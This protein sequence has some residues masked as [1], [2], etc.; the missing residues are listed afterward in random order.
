MSRITIFVEFVL[1]VPD[2]PDYWWT[3]SGEPIDVA[4]SRARISVVEDEI[5]FPS[6]FSQYV[7]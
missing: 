4:T 6:A 7:Q 5:L 2:I 1:I 3:D